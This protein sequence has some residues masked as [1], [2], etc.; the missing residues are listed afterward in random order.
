[1][2]SF[3][4]FLKEVKEQGKPSYKIY[5][6][7]DGVLCD[8]LGGVMET[9]NISRHPFQNQIDTFLSTLKGSRLEW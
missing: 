3:K 8:F 2:I 5:C 4:Q 1:M 6:D 9:L 7:M